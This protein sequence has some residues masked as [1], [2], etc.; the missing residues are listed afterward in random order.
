MVVAH[1]CVFQVGRVV[2]WQENDRGRSE[3]RVSGLVSQ[4]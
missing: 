4:G 3:G 2:G 1:G